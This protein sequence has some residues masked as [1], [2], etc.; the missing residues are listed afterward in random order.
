MNYEYDF[1][2]NLQEIQTILRD[3]SKRVKAFV[4]QQ[5]QILNQKKQIQKQMINQK[6]LNEE[7]YKRE[8]NRIK[9]NMSQLEQQSKNQIIA[10]KQQESEKEEL[11]AEINSIEKNF[12]KYKLTLDLL[13]D[14][15]NRIK[16][17][18]VQNAQNVISIENEIKAYEFLYGIKISISNGKV[19]FNFYP[20]DHE[21]VLNSSDNGFIL[22]ETTLPGNISINKLVDELNSTREL[23]PFLMTIRSQL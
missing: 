13:K 6:Q 12:D 22:S 14:K 2:S 3:S 9:N 11:I 5:R 8:T 21:I 16:G 4:D 1:G 17:E 10:S 20:S 18:R 7:T 15:S 23:L 19:K